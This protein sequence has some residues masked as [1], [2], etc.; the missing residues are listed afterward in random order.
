MDQLADFLSGAHWRQ[1]GQHTFFCDDSGLP[2]IWIK[3]AKY[4]PQQLKGCGL[5]AWKITGATKMVEQKG[6]IKPVSGEGT[7]VGGEALTPDSSP[8]LFEKEVVLSG[9]LLFILAIP[10]SP[11]PA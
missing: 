1:T 10:Q 5:Q 6:F 4:F 3:V 9:S 11:S 8:V 2:E 7:I